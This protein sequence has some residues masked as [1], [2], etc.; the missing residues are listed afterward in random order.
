MCKVS[1]IIVLYNTQIS[2]SK[3][4][5]TALL[6]SF[7]RIIVC[8]NSEARFNQCGSD[9]FPIDYFSLGGNQGLPAAYMAGIQKSLDCDYVCFFDDDTAIPYDYATKI[10]RD[11]KE[12]RADI[13]LPMV[14][15]GSI[16]ISPC[17]KHGFSF[18]SF[19]P[20][21]KIKGSSFSA[22]NSGMCVSTAFLTYCSFNE[23]LFLD[24]VDHEFLREAKFKNAKIVIDEKIVLAQDLSL[25]TETNKEA[26]L[27]RQQIFEKDCKVYYS[28]N[29]FE[30]IYAF[31]LIKKRRVLLKVKFSK[32]A[33]CVHDHPKGITCD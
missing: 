26:V 6:N 7:D 21:E 5:N 12:T 16:L 32:F 29:F 27:H 2:D 1:A 11:I 31:Y 23:N 28:K 10:R 3:A 8:D 24:Y 4:I 18:R 15:C 30:K 25:Y 20:S 17:K 22:I 33:S 13:Y 19:L 14:Y 9:T